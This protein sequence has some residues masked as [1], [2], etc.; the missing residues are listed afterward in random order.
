MDVGLIGTGNMG[1][2][3]GPKILA[4]GHKLTVFDLR[5]E[6]TA[7]LCEAGATWADTPAAVA[8]ASSVV[9]TSL[10]S[11]AVVEEVV[12]DPSTGI[13]AGLAPGG[14]YIDHSTS[15][16]AGRISFHPICTVLSRPT[17]SSESGSRSSGPM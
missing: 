4:A 12:F 9:L 10:P 6:A 11:P 7:D 2:R 17:P 16:L 15:T 1:G 14:V 5:R 3:F 13:L 8:Q